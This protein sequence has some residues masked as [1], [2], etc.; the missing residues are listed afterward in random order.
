MLYFLYSSVTYWTVAITQCLPKKGAELTHVCGSHN[1][2]TFLLVRAL[3]HQ[4]EEKGQVNVCVRAYAHVRTHACALCSLS[5][6]TKIPG[7][8]HWFLPY[9]LHLILSPLKGPSSKYNMG[10]KCQHLEP[11]L[12]PCQNHSRLCI[13]QRSPEDR[14]FVCFSVLIYFKNLF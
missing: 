12:T 11:T 4:R 5:P 10:I 13:N 9:R 1:V 14:E 2:V 3:K 6:L 8:N 7:F